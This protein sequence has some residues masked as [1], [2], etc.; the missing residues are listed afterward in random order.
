MPRAPTGWPW[1][2]ARGA[3]RPPRLAPWRASHSPPHPSSSA[4]PAAAPGCAR[5][6]AGRE[7]RLRHLVDVAAVEHLVLR[8]SRVD[9]HEVEVHF[10]EP[11]VPQLH[12]LLVVRLEDRRVELALVAHRQH[13]AEPLHVEAHDLLVVV[14]RHAPP[15]GQQL[16]LVVLRTEARQLL[17]HA[18]ESLAPQAW[19]A[20]R[21]YPSSRSGG[22][23][24]WYG[25]VRLCAASSALRWFARSSCASRWP[26]RA[27]PTARPRVP[28]RPQRA[29]LPLPSLQ[30]VPVLPRAP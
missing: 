1:S 19:R 22:I 12:Q 18:T 28:A 14:R 11:L 6:S 25:F 8:L 15:T 9:Q 30:P 5:A 21:P 2:R 16:Q 26:S 27:Q 24:R 17:L 13:L 29:P 7:H 10:L 20:A 23:A 3:A 4:W